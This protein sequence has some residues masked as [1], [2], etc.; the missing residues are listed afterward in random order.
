MQK[1]HIHHYVPQWYQRRFLATAKTTYFYL[2]LHPEIIVHNGVSHTK[3]AL[4]KWG[5]LL[6]FFRENLYTLK[7]GQTTSDA[8][9]KFFFGAVDSHGAKATAH[10]RDYQGVTA[11]TGDAAQALTAYMGAQR[12]RTPRGLDE[13]KKRASSENQRP[14]AVMVALQSVFQ[15]YTTMWMEG[16]WEFVWAKQS[17]TKFIVSDNPVTFYC[18]AMFP[19]EW[20]YP[21]D[22]SLKQIGTRT[23]FP[24]GPESCLIITHL[25]LTRNPS[26]TPTEYRENARYYDQTAKHMGEIQFGRELDEDEV[27]RINYMLKRRATRYIAASNEEWLY[28]ERR[29]STTDWKNLD[30]D[31]FLLP[32]LW[33]IPFISQI[34]MGGKDWGWA[35]DEYGRHPGQPGYRNKRMREQ[36]WITREVGKR[37]WA[38]KRAGKPVAQIDEREHGDVYDKMM[39]EYLQEEELLPSGD[40]QG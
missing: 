3:K 34:V 23:L 17:P 26:S 28:P 31:W 12:F 19:S 9:E 14:N 20:T 5:P 25:Q 36:D 7:F 1:S 2:D 11:G 37:D 18:K 38:K 39:Y 15:S 16:V 22:P 6:C 27:L 40:G 29:V 13:I 24:L 32:N 8:M 30:D 35:M 10:F 21:E 33:K 4:W